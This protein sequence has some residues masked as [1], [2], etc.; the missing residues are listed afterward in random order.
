MSQTQ[1]RFLGNIFLCPLQGSKMRPVGWAGCMWQGWFLRPLLRARVL[2]ITMVALAAEMLAGCKHFDG[3]VGIGRLSFPVALGL[4]ILINTEPSS[5]AVPGRSSH[6]GGPCS[7]PACGGER[8]HL[9]Y[10]GRSRNGMSR[11]NSGPGIHAELSRISLLS[12]FI[13]VYTA[14]CPVCLHGCLPPPLPFPSITE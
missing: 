10:S 11:W 5:L 4:P 8:Q 2:Y 7:L 12:L 9:C 13:Y 1:L 3:C 14:C 6:S